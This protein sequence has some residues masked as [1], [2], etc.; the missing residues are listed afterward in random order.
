MRPY[1]L[2]AVF[3]LFLVLNLTACMTT[4]SQAILI[5]VESIEATQLEV[6]LVSRLDGTQVRVENPSVEGDELVGTTPPRGNR[7]RMIPRADISI[8]LA[9]IVSI[10]VISESQEPSMASMG[11]TLGAAIL[12][13]GAFFVVLAL[14]S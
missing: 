6:V 5:P 2:R 14:V 13:G 7:G 12:I 1:R 10:A 3:L 4:R 8:P 11:L 9:D